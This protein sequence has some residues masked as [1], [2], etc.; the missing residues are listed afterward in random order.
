[1]HT[2]RTDTTERQM[3][4]AA[5]ADVYCSP[6]CFR[7]RGRDCENP[8]P[9]PAAEP[10]ATPGPDYWQAL[11]ADLRAVADRVAALAGTPAHV[12]FV[13]V[14]ICAGLVP[15]EAPDG[16]ATVDAIAAAFGG[17]ASTGHHNRSALWEHRVDAQVG[18]VVLSAFAIVP[19]PAS[20]EDELRAEVEALRAQLAEGGAQ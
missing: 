16:I 1:M 17:S 12:S 2:D 13:T 14:G 4:A 11:A 3:C 15:S 5:Q 20:V 18:E 19:K 9:T 8:L 10:Q 7:S 6:A